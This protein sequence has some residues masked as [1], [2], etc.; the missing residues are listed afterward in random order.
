M[1][2]IHL[3][4]LHI[5]KRINDFSMLDDQ[6]YILAEIL[7]IIDEQKPDAV[8]ILG[9][10]YDKPIPSAEAVQ[11]VDSFLTRLADRD[12]PVF[13]ISGN[14]DSAARI[15][16]GSQLMRSRHVYMS[17]VF[18]GRL[19]PIELC[20]EYG[21]I[22]VYLLPFIRPADVRTCFPDEDVTDYNQ[23]MKVAL[24]H[25]PIDTSRR[26]IILAHQFITG[27][28]TCESEEIRVGGLDTID[29]SL[30]DAFDYVALGHL[31]VAQ[32]VGRA[33]VRY[34]GT[35]LK[36]SFSEAKHAK[37][38]TVVEMGKKG[39]IEISSIPLVPRRDMREIKGPFEKITAPDVW[40]GTDIDD[41][42]H[43][44]LTDE[45]DVVDAIGKLRAI[46]PNLMRLD[47]DNKRTQEQR[48]VITGPDMAQRSPLEL[49]SEFFEK[50]NN[51]PMTPEQKDLVTT[52]IQDVW[53]EQA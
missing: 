9:D 28:T 24:A 23:A 18:D 38:V 1:K 51:Q 43:V 33:E 37:S 27:A 19:D 42:I 53:G 36:Y 5:G 49:F 31:H 2:L 25:N 35:P 15:A 44:T 22:D 6:R 26:N 39:D 4:D 3:S 29:A 16:F 48:D 45:V 8:L 20:D 7:D 32:H 10:V 11:L 14:H 50:Q 17:P 21:P 40:E 12:E 52:L 46:Y 47:Y 30:F 41:Y 34:C 13:V